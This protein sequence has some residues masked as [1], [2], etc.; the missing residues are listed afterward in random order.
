MTFR[1]LVMDKKVKNEA[2]FIKTK[3]DDSTFQK[4]VKYYFLLQRT[5][6]EAV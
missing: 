1:I 4:S 5:K 6:Y 3:I 2:L